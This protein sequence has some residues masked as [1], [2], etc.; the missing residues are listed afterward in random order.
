MDKFFKFLKSNLNILNHFLNMQHPFSV[1][2]DKKSTKNCK[3]KKKKKG[4]NT[5]NMKKLCR[6]TCGLCPDGKLIKAIVAR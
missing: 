1:C 6:K 4:C 5:P 2:E 3:N